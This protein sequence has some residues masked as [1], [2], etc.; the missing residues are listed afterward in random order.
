MT[1]ESR[2]KHGKCGRI[3]RLNL[4]LIEERGSVL[5]RESFHR[6]GLGTHLLANAAE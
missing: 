6:K 2:S 1:D 5:F 3:R 4:E